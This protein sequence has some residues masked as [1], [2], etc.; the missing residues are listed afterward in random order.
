MLQTWGRISG[1]FIST[2]PKPSFDLVTIPWHITLVHQC[3]MRSDEGTK[4]AN[5][6]TDLG[7]SK[8][9]KRAR[10]DSNRNL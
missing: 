4:I 8:R 6:T 2:L 1:Q 3:D 10:Y 5:S 9:K 7:G